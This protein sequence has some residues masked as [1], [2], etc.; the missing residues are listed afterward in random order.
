MV[1][2]PL[3]PGQAT[4]GHLLFRVYRLVQRE[5]YRGLRDAGYPEIRDA[6]SHVLRHIAPEGTR[7]SA[8]AA[9]A[10]MTKQYMTY[11]VNDMRT[12]GLAELVDDPDDGRARRVILTE[13]GQA[14]YETAVRL[15]QALEARWAANV[16][17]GRMRTMRAVMRALAAT[18]EH[19]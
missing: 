8:L 13:R 7:L 17:A 11:L 16:G 9:A 5:V 18:D 4:L 10:G 19:A 12:L 3:A 2:M 1:P 14:A 6:H 15:S